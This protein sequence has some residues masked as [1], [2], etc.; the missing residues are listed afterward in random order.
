MMKFAISAAALTL[1]IGVGG[2]DQEDSVAVTLAS[3]ERDLATIHPGGSAVAG[4]STREAVY[5][6]AISQLRA[7]SRDGT[8]AQKDAANM[9]LAQA[10]GGMARLAASRAAELEKQFLNDATRMRALLD[11][12]VAQ[13]AHGEALGNVNLA[14][15][16]DELDRAIAAVDARLN[17]AQRRR[18]QLRGEAE[19]FKS[20]ADQH[21]RQV[22][23]MRADAGRL[24]SQ[25]LDASATQAA[26]LIEQAHQ[27]QRE[28]A[29]SEVE[30]AR[31]M[32]EMEKVTPRVEE[33]DRLIASLNE[34]RSRLAAARRRV[35]VRG[36][37]ARQQSQT[38]RAEA[39]EAAEAV[40]L[41]LDEMEAMRNGPLA[42]RWNEATTQAEGAVSA[43]RQARG[44]D[45]AT[46][47][48]LVG[49]AQLRLAEMRL[50]MARGLERYALM[51]DG[52]AS[53]EPALPF[54]DRVAQIREGVIVE[55]DEARQAAREA[56]EEAAATFE[57]AA[58]RDQAIRDRLDQ[59]QQVLH[60]IAGSDG[61]N[62]AG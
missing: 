14:N 40:A 6:R 32:A 42:E 57:G 22:E 13:S 37:D 41:A 31:Q 30:A 12:Y 7:A 15:E 21:T 43:M 9:M 16:R 26:E 2:C 38:A 56:V 49:E 17:E 5:S 44:V 36:Q 61:A 20:L 24:R 39:L 48:M 28:A 8:D 19:R 59:M 3:V 51:L 52:L 58:V 34:E 27:I 1:A 35:D 46:S 18:E 11:L 23:A 47:S 62:G 55:R 25:A 29:A 33:Q 50:G 45:R 53:V 60:G 10:Q 4:E 54:A